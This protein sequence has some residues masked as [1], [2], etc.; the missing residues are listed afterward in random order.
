MIPRLIWCYWDQGI[1]SAPYLVKKCINTWRINNPDWE[2]TLIERSS[3]NQFIELKI[4]SQI[5]NS[6]SLQKQSVL[7]RL[8][9][10]EKYGGVWVDATTYC[11][12]RLNDWID[13]NTSDA[14]F[15]AFQNPGRDRIISNWFLQRRE[16][17]SL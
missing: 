14:Q 4:P 8:L 3:I 6:L 10:L 11:Q 5:F 12:I 16:T 17:Q 9:L 7:I 15:F 2:F 1:S 13:D